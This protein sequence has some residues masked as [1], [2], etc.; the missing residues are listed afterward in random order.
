METDAN[1]GLAE[2]LFAA[3]VAGNVE[4]VRN[5]YSPDARVWH[6]FDG[7]EQTVDENLRVLRWLVRNVSNLR[8]E[9]IRRRRTDDG[10]VQQHVLRGTSRSGQ[11]L[12]L[13]A[14]MICTVKDDHITRLEEYFDPAQLAPLSTDPSSPLGKGD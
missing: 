5:I 12:N 11:Q 14:C 13:A 3:I 10:F 9:E 1:L 2:R 6:N 8:Y 7:V 4:A